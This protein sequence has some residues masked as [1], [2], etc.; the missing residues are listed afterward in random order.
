M[1]PCP[2]LGNDPPPRTMKKHLFRPVQL[3]DMHAHAHAPTYVDF[4][5][6][7]AVLK[8]ISTKKLLLDFGA[9]PGKMKIPA[10]EAHP[11]DFFFARGCA[12]NKF[13][14]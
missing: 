7:P 13:C 5:W 9:S 3:V 12:G 1:G 11:R 8:G 6:S 4:V 14:T 2:L 10:M